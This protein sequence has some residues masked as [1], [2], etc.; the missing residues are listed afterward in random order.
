MSTPYLDEAERAT[1]VGLMHEGRL[2]ALDRPARVRESVSGSVLEVICRD[3]RGAVAVLRLCGMYDDV[4]L[5]GDRLNV[6]VK[7]ASAGETAI[8][9]TLAE[10]GIEVTSLRKI[11][12]SLENAFISLVRNE[13]GER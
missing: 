10:A 6:V 9:A 4:Q 2:L 8:R 13:R 5:F 11:P 1:R 3:I 12:S 7:D